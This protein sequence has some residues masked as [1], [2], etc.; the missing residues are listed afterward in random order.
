MTCSLKLPQNSKKSSFL[1][2]LRRTRFLALLSLFFEEDRPK[3]PKFIGV[4]LMCRNNPK[5][6]YL[7]EFYAAVHAE[8]S[9]CRLLRA[10]V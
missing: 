5:V 1:K 3:G 10:A 2:K 7:L 4:G 8:L 9:I 6:M